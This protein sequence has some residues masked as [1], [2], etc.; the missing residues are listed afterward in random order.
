MHRRYDRNHIPIELLRTLIAIA[1]EG[2]FTKAGTVLG[3][4]Q[5]AISAQVR[6]LEQLI[7][8]DIFVKAG[9]GLSLT[10]LGQNI[11]E[12]ADR[13]LQINDYI[14]SLPGAQFSK[15]LVRIGIP[16]SMAQL[17]A[18]PMFKRC[19]SLCSDVQ[20]QWRCDKSV[21]LQR[22]IAGGYLDIAVVFLTTQASADMVEEWTELL[23][24]ACS[25]DLLVSPNEPI[26]Y[27]SWPNDPMDDIAIDALEHA[28]RRYVCS[29]SGTDFS[30]RSLAASAGLGYI[31]L[32]ERALV[33]GL[34]VARESFL[35]KLPN[36]RA[37]VVV[38]RDFDTD[39]IQDLLRA[40]IDI[41]RPPGP[42]VA[43]SGSSPASRRSA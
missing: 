2:S 20:I 7:G 19:A 17:Y 25:P 1:S 21:E 16:V 27:I 35:P 3:L 24:W 22:A 39:S 18:I 26:P 40:I 29:F 41:A 31:L 8:G 10:T 32:P 28:G 30:S 42:T 9:G 14:L 5:S 11:A 37:G 33:S 34:K 4:T 6:R 12:H 23:A 43:K 38:R 36:L 13:I 15:K